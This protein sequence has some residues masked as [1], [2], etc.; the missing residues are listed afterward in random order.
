M[1]KCETEIRCDAI[2]IEGC[3]IEEMRGLTSGNGLELPPLG[4]GIQ[5]K[6][7]IRVLWFELIAGTLIRSNGGKVVIPCVLLFHV[8]CQESTTGFNVGLVLLYWI[9][10]GQTGTRDEQEPKHAET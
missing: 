9:L 2:G 1:Q 5:Q 7:S 8:G 4:E 10:L 3:F 6:A